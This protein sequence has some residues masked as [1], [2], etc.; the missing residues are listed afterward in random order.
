MEIIE[1]HYGEE[2]ARSG[3][4]AAV[5]KGTFFGFAVDGQEAGSLNL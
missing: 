2:F 1:R 5:F 3:Y 4:F